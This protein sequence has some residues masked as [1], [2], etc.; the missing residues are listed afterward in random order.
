MEIANNLSRGVVFS[1]M[2]IVEIIHLVLSSFSLRWTVLSKK[3]LWTAFN[4]V[5]S[6]GI[7]ERME[8]ILLFQFSQI[9]SLFCT[10]QLQLIILLN[11]DSMMGLA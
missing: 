10:I 5:T 4:P 8:T 11:T 3:L 2:F 1:V 7:A 6:V 9:L